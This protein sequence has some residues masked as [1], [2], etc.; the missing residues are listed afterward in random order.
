MYRSVDLLTIFGMLGGG[1]YTRMG[2]DDWNKILYGERR[3]RLK[4]RNVETS[5]RKKV[6][7]HD[8]V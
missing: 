8:A 4:K 1:E 3:W 2:K 7:R 5:R 6:R